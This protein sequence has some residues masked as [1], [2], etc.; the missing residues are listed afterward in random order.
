MTGGAAN[1]MTGA[2]GDRTASPAAGRCASVS[3][4]V[5]HDSSEEAPC[6]VVLVA[7][8]GDA[9]AEEAGA[10][11]GAALAE[12]ANGLLLSAVPAAGVGR[13]PPVAA[14]VGSPANGLKPAA[15]AEAPAPAAAKLAASGAN[16]L[17]PAP[18]VASASGGR[19]PALSGASTANGLAPAAV[20]DAG[21]ADDDDDGP[22]AGTVL[23]GGTV[24][25]PVGLRA[26][27][28]RGTAAAAAWEAFK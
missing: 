10:G 28:E 27:A 18:A 26:P 16:G 9:S 13:V 7:C 11:A 21:A 2:I 20:G 24:P 3:P 8:G 17:K 4:N 25:L 23:I 19:A 1:R 22:A 6:G 5:T 12:A 15:A 14:E